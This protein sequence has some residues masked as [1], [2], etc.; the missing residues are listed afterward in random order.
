MVPAYA[1]A[2]A[3]IYVAV[4]MLTGMQG[5]AWSD[6]TEAAPA[7]ITI[8]MIPLTFSIANGIALGFISYVAIK[9][10][11][12]RRSDISLGAWFLAIIFLLKFA[13]I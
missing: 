1:T 2:G 9:L 6:M 12:G 4:L 3:L 10:F 13:F 5:L 7:L 8:V 11:V